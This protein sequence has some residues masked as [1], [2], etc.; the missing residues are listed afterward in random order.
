VGYFR[1]DIR[2][3]LFSANIGVVATGTNNGFGGEYAGY[4]LNTTRNGGSAKVEGW[5]L[6]YQQELTFL[7]GLLRG[8]G[9]YANL[10][11][12]KTEGDYGVPGTTTT[13][14]ELVNF[15]PRTTNAGLSFRYRGLMARLNVS[16]TS[17]HLTTGST[18]AVSRVY[19]FPRTILNTNLSYQLGRG[20]SLFADVANLT[21]EPQRWYLG[22]KGRPYRS[23]LQGGTVTLGLRGTF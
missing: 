16:Y 13:A 21:D 22:H 1:K 17:S 14:T 11:D 15:V 9:V 7:P 18:A 12:L 4:Q 10:T 5:E 23:T 20:L 8:L 2:D 19:L 6:S 3:F